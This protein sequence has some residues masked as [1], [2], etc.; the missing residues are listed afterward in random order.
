MPLKQLALKYLP[1]SVL[2][3]VRARHYQ[4]Q[5]RNY[6]LDSEPDI[7]GC[8][9][10]L[11]PGDTVLDIGAN[12]GVYTRF[13]SEFVGPSGHVHALEPIPETYFYLTG[14]VRSLGLRNVTCYNLAASDKDQ[15]HARMSMPEYTSGGNNIYEARL[16]DEG[17][18]PV[19]TAQIDTLFSNVSPRLIKCDVEGHEV[20]CLNGARDLI[21]RCR[22][23]C[24]VEVSSP[25][26]FEIF[27]SMGYEP[28][29]W[30]KQRFRPKSATDKSPNFFFFAS[31]DEAA[32]QNA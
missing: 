26:T 27:A 28:F 31:E 11:Q 20:A 5:L 24:V 8:K 17:E 32:Q 9:S 13:C 12:I 14:N 7:L 2:R 21:A 30:E 3:P 22:P 6:P 29:I 19:K 10:L 4:N 23:R 15:D 1:Q 16:S 18:I 25:Q